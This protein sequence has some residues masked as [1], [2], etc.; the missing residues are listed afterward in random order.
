MTE[1]EDL[2]LSFRS[3][4]LSFLLPT[5]HSRSPHPVILAAPILSFPPSPPCHSRRQ[6]AGI[7]GFFFC[8][9]AEASQEG[10]AFPGPSVIPQPGIWIPD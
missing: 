6:L 5:C 9:V 4:T 8:S 3:P 10:R 1:R 2:L 7:Q